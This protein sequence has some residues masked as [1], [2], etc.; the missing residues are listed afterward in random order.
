MGRECNS[1]PN[2]LK[3]IDID[4]PFS[5]AFIP[6]MRISTFGA[7]VQLRSGRLALT[8]FSLREVPMNFAFWRYQLILSL[9]FLFWGE[10]FVSRGILNQLTFNFAIF[11]PLGFLVGYRRRHEDLRSAY[12]AALI[13]NLLSYLLAYLAD[14][15]I[16][17]WTL[18]ILDFT[19]LIV[20]LNIG[21]YIGL[22]AQSKE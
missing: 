1:L 3:G 22:R 18:V 9:L 19:S 5:P 10:F 20:I 2:F 4:H 15:P 13:F 12:L 8:K 7:S 16:G 6:G 11:Y 14:V 21:N 17:S